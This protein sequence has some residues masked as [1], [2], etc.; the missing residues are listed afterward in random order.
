MSSTYVSKPLVCRELIG[1][2][3]ELNELLV[4]VE[5]ASQGQPRLA[6]LAGEAGLGKTRLARELAEKCAAQGGL[7]LSG[8]SSLNDRGL[9]FGP[10]LDAFRRHYLARAGNSQPETPATLAVLPYLLALLPELAPRYPEVKPLEIDL[11]SGSSAQQQNRLFHGLMTALRGLAAATSGPVLLLLEDLH[12]ADETS[13]ELLAFLARQ[14]GVN[15]SGIGSTALTNQSDRLIIVGTYRHELL[16]ESQSLSRLLM[17]LANQRQLY[18]IRLAPLGPTDHARLLSGILG[19]NVSE[20][21]AALFYGRDEGNPF[22]AEELLGAMVAAGQLVQQDG[23][24]RRQAGFELNL[25]MTLKASI[26]ERLV[27]LPSADQEA[28]AYAAVI[29]REFD[30][31]LLARVS[32]LAERELLAVLRRAISLQLIAEDNTFPGGGERYQFRHALTREAIYTEMLTRE[33]RSCHR[34]VAE[35]LEQSLK[36]PAHQPSNFSL[37]QRLAEH[38]WL[39]GLP[40]RAAPY[41]LEEAK[42]AARLFAFREERYYLQ[43]A[44][45]ALSETSPERLELLDRLGTLS[46]MAMEVPVALDWFGMAIEGYR[47]IGQPRRAAVLLASTTAVVW[48]F[49]SRKIVA[50]LT[51]V[52]AAAKA[53]FADPL[54]Q[55]LDALTIYAQFALSLAIADQHTQAAIWVGRAMALAENLTDLRKYGPLQLCM[56]ATGIGQ[57][58]GS[59][60]EAEKGLTAMQQV[61]NFGRQFNLP[62][63]TMLGYGSLSASL[64]SLGRSEQSEQVLQEIIEQG[65]NAESWE[66]S[67]LFDRLTKIDLAWQCYFSGD[68]DKGIAQLRHDIAQNEQAG[69]LSLPTLRAVDRVP[70]AHFLIARHELEEAEQLLDFALPQIEPLGQF[71]YLALTLWGYAK[72]HTAANRP[73]QAADY[74]ERLLALWKTTEDSGTIIP[75]LLDA[76]KFYVDSGNLSKVQRW[77]D[78]LRHL[79]TA[80]GNP[81]LQAALWEAEGALEAHPVLGTRGGLEKSVGLLRQAVDGWAALRR[82]PQQGLASLRLA[83]VLLSTVPGAKMP[84]GSREEAD[85]LLNWTVAEFERLKMPLALAEAENLR[86]LTRLDVQ[87]KRRSTLEEARRPYKDLTRRELQVLVQLAA[88]LTNKEIGLTLK[89]TEG[90]V[91]LHVNHILSKLGCDTRT[92]AATYAIEQGWAKS[93]LPTG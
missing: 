5:Q 36:N 23:R 30:F 85:N 60:T 33:R 6:L 72:L 41:A 73:A 58:D 47:R 66:T 40:E 13:L 34:A 25:P 56:L 53:A 63:I 84:P 92:Q 26:T 43:I 19:Q 88:G 64:I 87:T 31:D 91:E 52:E 32:G 49:D 78:E 45:A 81:A 69:P 3:T 75:I 11:S 7:I 18:E 86:H 59:A 38:Y 82:R 1:R 77:L 79:A 50:L 48:F 89:I 17:Q 35:A 70:L 74:Y 16:G 44:L 61:L 10:F 27:T 9:P 65:G 20:E 28:L 14:L 22:Y 80:T 42:H 71:T 15:G 2:E 46:L 51:E 93:Q 90:T 67:S 8:Q 21:Y 4:A 12:W 57:V 83:S 39:A 54:A 29:G 24:W 37:T 68:W 76:V 62:E 55:D